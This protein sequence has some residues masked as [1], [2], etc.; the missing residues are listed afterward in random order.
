MRMLAVGRKL[1]QRQTIRLAMRM[2]AR[3]PLPNTGFEF[4]SYGSSWLEADLLILP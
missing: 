1:A 2:T 4:K 3:H